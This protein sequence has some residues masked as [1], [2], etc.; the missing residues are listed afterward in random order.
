[1]DPIIIKDSSWNQL[2]PFLGCL[3]VIAACFQSIPKIENVPLLIEITILL[4][5]G[6]AAH[7][8]MKLVSKKSLLEID[9]F[10]IWFSDWRIEIVRWKDIESAF[11]KSEGGKDYVCFTVCDRSELRR[12]FGAVDLSLYDAT[13]LPG[14]GDL[15]LNATRLGVLAHDV[16]NYAQRQI[17]KKS[18]KKTDQSLPTYQLPDQQ[19]TWR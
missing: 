2:I 5:G 10:G 13:R 17:A 18:A 12:R 14:Y 19:D 16:V 4:F 15:Y 8:L 3:A 6:I 7:F 9:E 1:M 11:I